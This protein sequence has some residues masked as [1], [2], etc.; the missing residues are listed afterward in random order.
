MLHASQQFPEG[1]VVHWFHRLE[2]GRTGCARTHASDILLWLAWAVAE[3]VAA[4]G[5]E[6]ILDEETPHLEASSLFRHC[7]PTSTVWDSIRF[8][9]RV[10]TR[11]TGIRWQ[12]LTSS[13]TGASAPTDYR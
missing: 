4:T 13:S 8:D 9:R 2:D 12:P 10:P 6:T 3:Y 5:D 7:R 11:C 1:D